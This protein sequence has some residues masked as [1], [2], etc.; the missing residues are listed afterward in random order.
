MITP[1]EQHLG[2]ALQDLV[3]TQPFQPDTS[4][5]LQRGAARR[6][7]A[8][9]VRV[10][11][12]VAFGAAAALVT[13]TGTRA[14]THH[15][16]NGN[17]TGATVPAGTRPLT[18]LASYITAD[19]AP[20]AGD[21]TL[22]ER[23]QSY[24]GRSP[25]QGFDLYTDSGEYFYAGSESGLPAAI[26][27]NANQGGGMFAREIAAAEYAASGNL[28]TADQR[29]AY[30][31][32]SDGRPPAET[33]AQRAQD[34][35]IVAR[36]LA[37]SG[38]T[39]PSLLQRIKAGAGTFNADNYIWMDSQQALQAGAGNPQVRAG[40][41]RIL[42]TLP[43]ITVTRTD[44]GGRAALA[45]TASGEPDLPANYH[46][47]ITID[48]STGIPVSL[49]GATNGAA[50]AVTVTYHVSRVTVSDIEAGRF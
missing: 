11:A 5:I 46:E 12:G 49:V 7:R 8:N 35:Q 27:S 48:A 36:K 28:V 38:K 25:V 6:R 31:P 47:T 32:F 14:A 24:P 40:V 39:D 26:A 16:T 3:A 34:A 4:S 20:Q 43:G 42:S 21:A 45:I 2:E 17:T 18:E 37:A 23:T 33:A 22:V 10:T 44:V 1:T 19:T 41:L 50:P 9:A 15:P 29:M 30:A 13:I